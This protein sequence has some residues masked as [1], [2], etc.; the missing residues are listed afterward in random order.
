MVLGTPQLVTE[1]PRGKPN[2][3]HQSRVGWGDTVPQ[4][5]GHTFQPGT[6]SP[7]IQFAILLDFGNCESQKWVP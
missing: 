2:E 3:L 1:L 7:R 4:S 6:P 5:L